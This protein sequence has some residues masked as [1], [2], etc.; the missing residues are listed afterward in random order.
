LA[1]SVEFLRELILTDDNGE[2]K[3]LPK[4]VQHND[5]PWH[6]LNEEPPEGFDFSLAGN[7]SQLTKWICNSPDLRKLE[8]LL[9]SNPDG[10][11]GKRIKTQSREVWFSDKTTYAKANSNRIADEERSKNA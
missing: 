1:E 11:F 3:V 2:E 9:D 6:L 7:L 10:C 4:A 5:S 8:R